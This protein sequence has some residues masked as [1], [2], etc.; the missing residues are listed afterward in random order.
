MHIFVTAAGYI[1]YIYRGTILFTH[2]VYQY[3]MARYD[4]YLHKSKNRVPCQNG[5]YTFHFPP[6]T[7][8]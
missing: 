5:T 6:F 1:M 8:Y 4:T 2:I 7:A 3:I